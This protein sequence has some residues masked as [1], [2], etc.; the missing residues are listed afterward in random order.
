[1]W[2]L[3]IREKPLAAMNSDSNLFYTPA[4]FISGYYLYDFLNV[5]EPQPFRTYV[6]LEIVPSDECHFEELDR[7]T[8]V[9]VVSLGKY[10]NKKRISFQFNAIED[11]Y[12]IL[13]EKSQLLDLI[14]VRNASNA[15]DW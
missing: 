9:E 11:Q 1:M 13:S 8:I 14:V 6:I 15:S 5:F 3:G 12:F 4:H 7:G 10:Q 2:I